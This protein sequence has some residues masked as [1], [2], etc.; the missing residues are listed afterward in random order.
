MLTTVRIPLGTGN[1]I[2][3]GTGT[4]EGAVV[5]NVGSLFL[6][7]DGGAATTLYVKTTGTTATGW[8]AK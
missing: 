8:T 5:A 2:A 6:R 3:V 1:F 7:T 4:P